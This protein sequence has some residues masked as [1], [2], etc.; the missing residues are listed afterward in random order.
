LYIS[1]RCRKREGAPVVGFQQGG[2]APSIEGGFILDEETSFWEFQ[3]F[4]FPFRYHSI[5]LGGFQRYFGGGFICIESG[6]ISQEEGAPHFG[7]LLDPWV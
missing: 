4:G 6:T 5:I 7:G 3:V 2:G 1:Y